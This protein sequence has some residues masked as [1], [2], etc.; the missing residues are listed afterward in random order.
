MRDD[1]ITVL[2]GLPELTVRDEEE[3]AY[4]IRVRV[5]YR[6]R[7]AECPGCGE[8]TASVHSTRLQ[9]RRVLHA[10]E[11]AGIIITQWPMKTG[12]PPCWRHGALTRCT[13]SA[14]LSERTLPPAARYVIGRRWSVRRPV[15]GT[16]WLR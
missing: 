15:P 5:E 3:T 12:R 13:T 8:R 16:H 7:A 4:G 9:V 2:L 1:S 6:E 14:T 10:I 11:K